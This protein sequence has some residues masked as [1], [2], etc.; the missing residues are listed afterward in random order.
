MLKINIDRAID[1]ARIAQPPNSEII[2]LRSLPD[3]QWIALYITDEAPVKDFER[4]CYKMLECPL[5]DNSE[6]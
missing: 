1:R 3:G 5:F 2:E 4:L 6:L